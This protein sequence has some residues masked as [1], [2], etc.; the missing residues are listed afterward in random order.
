M[1]QMLKWVVGVPMMWPELGLDARQGILRHRP[2]NMTATMVVIAKGI[3]TRRKLPTSVGLAKGFHMKLKAAV[4][5][6]NSFQRM[7]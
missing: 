4:E 1:L 3:P 7:P 6:S 2:W 5:D